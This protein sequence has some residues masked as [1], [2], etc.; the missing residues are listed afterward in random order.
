MVLAVVLSLRGRV[1]VGGGASEVRSW[2]VE[3]A[4]MRVEVWMRSCFLRDETRVV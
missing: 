1:R 3:G 4:V 2:W